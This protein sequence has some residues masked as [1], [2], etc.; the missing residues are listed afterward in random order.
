MKTIILAGGYGTR[1]AEET[2]TK[3]KPMVEIGGQPILW[4]IMQIYAAFGYREF[5]TALGYKSE[6]IK[7]YFLDLHHARHNVSVQLASGRVEVHPA[8]RTDDWT[9]HMIETG[10]DTDTGGRLKRL[11]PY[12]GNGTFMMT[13]G[14][15][16]ADVDIGKLVAFHRGHGRLAT[17]TGVRPPSRFGGLRLDGELVVEYVE[18]P[19][20]GEGWING[21]FFVLEPQVLDLIAGDETRFEREPLETLARSGQLMAYLHD[22]FW[23]PMDTLRDVR[24]LNELWG[25]GAAPW[26]R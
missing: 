6:V 24:L 12:I 8:S 18:K 4:H 3:P 1:L 11:A 7:R 21:G 5:V 20:L 19:Q 23:Q 16:V 14:D 2:G 9:V 22:G 15:G 26:K 25:K 10:L 17:V 13:Y